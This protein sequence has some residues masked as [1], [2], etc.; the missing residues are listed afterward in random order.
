MISNNFPIL[1]DNPRAWRTYLGG[2]LIDELH[3]I[4]NTE[5]S[6]FPEEWIMSIISARNAGRE[7]ILDEG[8]SHIASDGTTLKALLDISPSKY[9][10]GDHVARFGNQ[11]GVLVK[12][13]DASERLTIQVHPDRTKAQELFSSPFGKT[14]C[15]HILGG[16][17]AKGEKPCIY[18]GFKEGITHE[19]WVA[20]FENQDIEGM[21]NAMHR[22]EV[23]PGDTIL[24]EGGVPHAIGEG[25]FL[26]EIQEPTDYTI[27][28]ERTTPSGFPV[29]DF[30]CHQG[31]G[32]D[33]MFDCFNFEGL[34]ADEVKK[35]WFIEESSIISKESNLI[36]SLIG[37]SNTDYF[38]L[39]KIEVLVEIEVD[40][41]KNFSGLYILSGE[42]KLF[43]DGKS[44]PIFQGQ[45][46]FVPD[47]CDG[48]SL[49]SSEGSLLKALN[50]GGPIAN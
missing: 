45:Q 32:F 17:T 6:H 5:N 43:A 47:G 50:F 27:R 3:N 46:F 22:F 18:F 35:R 21:L 36:S 37:K 8:M 23:S 11:T 9:L 28:V 25:C 1:L 29:A 15:W 20:L 30:M 14:E 38:W 44:I 4:K 12:I 41:P 48:F 2:K 40:C 24:I 10:G 13:I 26:V 19:K 34:T 42:G 7:H 31:L 39:N 49:K 16:K 33:A